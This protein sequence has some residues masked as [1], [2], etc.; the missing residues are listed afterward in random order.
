MRLVGL[1]TINN[2]SFEDQLLAL[3]MIPAGVWTVGID[4]RILS[5]NKRAAV[6]WGYTQAEM[7]CKTWMDITHPDDIDDCLAFM[8]T[9]GEVTEARATTQRRYIRADGRILHAQVDVAVIRNEAGEIE[10]YLAVIADITERVMAEEALRQREQWFQSVID[11][12]TDTFLA[13]DMDGKLVYINQAGLKQLGYER[14]EL[15]GCSIDVIDPDWNLDAMEETAR[16]L[17]VGETHLIRSRQKRKDGSVF[18]VEV[19]IGLAIHNGI[20]Y[21]TGFARDISIQLQ[22]EAQ[23]KQNEQ[24]FR[25]LYNNTPV[26]MHSI[27]KEG[28][29]VYVNDYWLQMFGYERE[30]VIGRRST[31]FLTEASQRYAI[32]VALPLFFKQ[33]Y[34]KDIAYQFVCKNGEIIDVLLS[35]VLTKGDDGISDHSL[36]TIVD[37]T[38]RNK[39]QAVIKQNEKR[40]RTLYNKSPIMMHSVNAEGIIIDVNDYWLSVMGYERDEVID[41]TVAR[42]FTEASMKQAITIDVPMHFNKG[43]AENLPYQMIKKDGRVID[44]LFSA[45]NQVDGNGTFT[46]TLATIKDVSEQKRTEQALRSSERRFRKLFDESY[47]FIAIL[48]EHGAVIDVNQT[49]LVELGVTKQVLQG[50]PVWRIFAI[51]EDDLDIQKV[52][53]VIANAKAGHS[54]RIE[55]TG[56]VRGQAQTFD[57]TFSPVLNDEDHINMLFVEGRNVTHLMNVTE[58]LRTVAIKSKQEEKKFKT[59][60]NDSSNFAAALSPEGLILDVNDRVTAISGASRSRIVGQIIWEVDVFTPFP[61]IQSALEDMLA[62]V[63][64]N[65]SMARQEMS[66]SLPAIPQLVADVIL[67]PVM[68]DDGQIDMMIIEAR[69]ITQ[70]AHSREQL[71]QSAEDKSLLLREVHHRVKNNLQVIISMLRVEGRMVKESAQKDSLREVINRVQSMALIH[72]QLHR[73]SSNLAEI[74]LEIYMHELIK[75]IGRTYR[76]DVL[77]VVDVSAIKLDIDRAITCGLIVNELVSN[78]LKYAFPD[79]RGTLQVIGRHESDQVQISVIDDGIGLSDVDIFPMDGSTGFQLIELMTDQLAADVSVHVENGTRFDVVFPF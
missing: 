39:M 11:Q 16:R 10:R 27:D 47:D 23:L 24:T 75:E 62:A 40:L 8:T 56:R 72:D 13:F 18:P 30:D 2:H 76:L 41:C 51:K 74:D 37:V 17:S 73:E 66:L 25:K 19:S 38:E 53:D 59:L 78:A 54:G 43:Y 68:A 50:L 9:L 28:K 7:R 58:Q 77:L 4:G 49:A 21:R 5:T 46:H 12:S 1:M 22:R 36:A 79:G 33:G 32:E 57:V 69:D 61:L 29:L 71:R 42:F 70:L 64:A 6:M 14:D 45:T 60:F 15:I 65:S 31:D 35:G 48:D 52:K 63:H 34:V 55:L 44:V 3:D 20:A 67:T 26:G